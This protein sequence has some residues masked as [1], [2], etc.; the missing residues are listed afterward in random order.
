M[1]KRFKKFNHDWE[2]DHLTNSKDLVFRNTFADIEYI[3]SELGSR[4][5][6]FEFECYD[7][8]HLYNLAHF[9][10]RGIVKPP[11]FIQSIFGLLGGIGNHDD[12]VRHMKITAD[13]LFGSSYVWS[14]LGAGSSQVR[15]GAQSLLRGGH[16]RVGLEDSLWVGKG[17]LAQSSAEQVRR[18]KSLIENLG[19]EAATPDEARN[20]LGLKGLA[21]VGF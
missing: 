7:T 12:D 16:V 6:R 4:G 3:I 20:L 5:T 14:V 21:G 11:F 10:D 8:G 9:V 19:Q 17:Q 15:I 1:L 2:R 13:R 18:M